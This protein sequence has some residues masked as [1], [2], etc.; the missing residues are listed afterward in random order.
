MPSADRTGAAAAQPRREALVEAALRVLLRDGPRGLSHRAVAAEAGLPLAATTYYFT[1]KDELLEEAL[2]RIAGAEAARLAAAA[3]EL[4]GMD[5]ETAAG[6]VG[7]KAL[8]AEYDMML[9]KFE[10]YMEAARRPSLRPACEAWIDSFR[11]LAEAVLR[12]GGVRD[13]QARARILVAA[14]DGLMVEHL[15]TAD[16]PPDEA[17]LQADLDCLFSALSSPGR[18]SGSP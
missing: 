12:A 6:A 13:P 1:S 4:G 8:L 18:S 5:L 14:I 16:G 17:A 11:A 10:V 2:Q 9:V 7:A 3:D 15:A